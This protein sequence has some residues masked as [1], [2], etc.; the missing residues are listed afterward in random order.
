[1]TR[2]TFICGFKKSLKRLSQFY[3]VLLTHLMT[4]LEITDFPPT[5]DTL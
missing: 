4:S 5:L 3:Y 1:M 2:L